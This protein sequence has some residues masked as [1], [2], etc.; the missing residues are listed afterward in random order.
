MR[1]LIISLWFYPSPAI[2]G[3]RPTRFAQYLTKMGDS[4]DVVCPHSRYQKITDKSE[5]PGNSRIFGTFFIR[6][7]GDAFFGREPFIQNTKI[8]RITNIFSKIMARIIRL[9]QIPDRSML[10]IPFAVF[11]SLRLIR[12]YRPNVI[13]V[14]CPE[15]GANVAGAIVQRLTRIPLV[16]DYDDPWHLS[17]KQKNSLQRLLNRMI[18]K[19]TLKRATHVIANTKEMAEAIKDAFDHIK[20]VKLCYPIH[21]SYVEHN[22]NCKYKPD[23]KIGLDLVHAG[24]LYSPRSAKTLIKAMLEL[25]KIFVNK[26]IPIPTLKSYGRIDNESKDILVKNSGIDML[27]DNSFIP[28]TDCMQKLSKADV[29]VL[30]AATEHWC[31]IPNKLFDYISCGRPVLAFS[32]P[33]RNSVERIVKETGIGW[34]IENGD[35]EAAKSLLYELSENKING[36]LI[37]TV[38]TDILKRYHRNEELRQLREVLLSACRTE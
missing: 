19:F 27:S 34:V 11:A 28:Y 33:G 14:S 38:K 30:F 24:N 31:Q 18:E 15:F 37:E 4:V 8:N 25:K 16:I 29:L 21:S 9:I 32:G 3:K 10:W 36:Q 6:F 17:A 35:I 22:Y 13:Y 20:S 26:G 23:P 12:K 1:V 5:G 2:G 7:G